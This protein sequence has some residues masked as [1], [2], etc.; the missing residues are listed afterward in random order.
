[1][2]IYRTKLPLNVMVKT[3]FENCKIPVEFLLILFSLIC[4]L[5]LL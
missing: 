4:A 1:V 2:K 3:N 5:K